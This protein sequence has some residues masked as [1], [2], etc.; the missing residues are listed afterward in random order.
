M[1]YNSKI[2]QITESQKESVKT[3]K[4]TLKHHKIDQK[5]K[6]N[7]LVLS[8]DISTGKRSCGSGFYRTGIFTEF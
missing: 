6:H 4:R 1:T 2:A 7:S 8:A 3:E 5:I